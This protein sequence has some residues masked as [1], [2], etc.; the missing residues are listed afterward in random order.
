MLSRS[1]MQWTWGHQNKG[2]EDNFRHPEVFF[3]ILIF[4]SFFGEAIH[5]I[6]NPR[7]L[8]PGL[9]SLRLW[10][11]C[12]RLV[13]AVLRFS[14]CSLQNSTGANKT[15]GRLPSGHVSSPKPSFWS[16]FHSPAEALIFSNQISSQSC[17]SKWISM[18]HVVLWNCFHGKKIT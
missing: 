4:A 8:E 9:M 3:S 18:A 15:K 5:E 2:Q 17:Q 7:M 1:E 13:K 6:N 10:M 16:S 14:Y 11:E 12:R